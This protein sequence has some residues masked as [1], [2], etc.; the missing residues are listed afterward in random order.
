M[1][2]RG[3][4]R[5]GGGRQIGVL[6]R[7]GSEPI[8][9]LRR[10][11]YSEAARHGPARQDF[12]SHCG[13]VSMATCVGQDRVEGSRRLE[14]RADPTGRMLTVEN[15]GTCRHRRRS[16]TATNRAAGGFGS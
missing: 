7:V 4:M 1:R 10:G 14:S 5:S 12:T 16:I 15:S 8:E 6:R 13:G 3:G 9:P 11:D 2:S